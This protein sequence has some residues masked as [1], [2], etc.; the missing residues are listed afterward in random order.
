MDGSDLG[1][2][3]IFRFIGR[4]DGERRTLLAAIAP[5][6]G[7]NQ[8]W[9]ILGGGAVF[10]AW[11][12][13][14]AASFSGLCLVMLLLAACILRPV[15]FTYRNK[16]RDPRWRSTYAALEVG[17][18]MAER[19]ISLGRTAATTFI[20]AFL[21][22]GLWV[23][24]AMNGY[25]IEGTFGKLSAHPVAYHHVVVTPGGWLENY[26]QH[27]VLWMAPSGALLFA[28]I[29]RVLLGMRQ[30]GAAFVSSSL[31][32]AATVLTAGFALFPFLMPSSEVYND[33]LTVWNASSSERTLRIMLV[34]VAILLPIVL[35][36]T[37][38]VF[39][40]LKGLIFSVPA[41]L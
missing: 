27:T 33:G 41:A 17:E 4:T 35:A 5:L 18:P 34:A 1:V 23:S 14:Y 10:G 6:W 7:G 13:L 11:P 21:I 31:T 32:Q 8:V 40:V 2:S 25:S 24:I 26:R 39:R 38:W 29:T 19:A 20:M 28:L 3:A 12:Q 30:A 15:G 9:F 36:Y 37:T 22:A 16:L